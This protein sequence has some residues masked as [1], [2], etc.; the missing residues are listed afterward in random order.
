MTDLQRFG[1][2]LIA[3]ACTVVGSGVVIGLIGSRATR[4]R[5]SP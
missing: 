1:L 5:R 2:F 4:R 3:F